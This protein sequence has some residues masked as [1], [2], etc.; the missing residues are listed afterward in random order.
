MKNYKIQNILKGVFILPIVLLLALPLLWLF[1]DM[2]IK[3]TT[4]DLFKGFWRV[5]E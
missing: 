2:T 5:E 3:E 4:K 1:N